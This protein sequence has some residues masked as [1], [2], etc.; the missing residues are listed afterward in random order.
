MKHPFLRRYTNIPSLVYLLS[1]GK[2][3]LLD[4]SAW[5]DKND[6]QFIEW[7]RDKKDGV[8]SVLAL[9]FTQ[10]TETYHHWQVYA[11]GPAGVCIHFRREE[12]L[13]A[14]KSHVQVRA[15]SVR[16][17]KLTDPR[18]KTLAVPDLPF[19]KRIAFKDER[20]FR[21]IYESDKPD[22]KLLDAPIP[23]GCIER[24]TLSPEMHSRLT[25]PLKRLLRSIPGCADLEVQ[26]STLLG[27]RE[28][29]RRGA[30]AV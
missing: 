3:T 24:V 23:L 21:I 18:A 14:V 6:S 8:A 27:N 29:L 25:T 5:P 15:R 19:L 17:R 28:W 1:E 13:A 26:R 16:Y 12:L 30:S 11:K 22:E 4:P 20:E 9:C 10:A 7:Y 2:L